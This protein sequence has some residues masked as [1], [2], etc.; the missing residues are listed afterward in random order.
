VKLS[1]TRLPGAHVVELE[2]LGDERGWF[3]RTF[4]AEA[5]AELGLDARVSQ[6]NASFNARAGT[7]RGLHYQA[8][9][10]GEAKLVRC[11]R[12]AIFDVIVDLRADS[13]A[14]CRWFGIEL[15]AGGAASL[16]VPAGVAHGFQ[17]LAD[18]SEVHYQMS[19]RYVPDAA[20]GV[21]WDDPAF[22]I[23]WPAAPAG[24]RVMSER[25][26]GYADFRP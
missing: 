8:A 19:Y 9:P 5:F 6:C 1:D 16:F 4:D 15:R 10:H 2:P 24:G 25:D 14:Y 7:L 18:D 11:T 12:G 26:A 22:A 20:R 17:T 13:P 3:A 23:D 21:R